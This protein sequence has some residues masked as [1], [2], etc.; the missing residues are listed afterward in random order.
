MYCTKC[1]KQLFDK[2]VV[3]P[4]CHTK[5]KNMTPNLMNRLN[6]SNFF[7]VSDEIVAVITATI[8][9]YEGENFTIKSISKQETTPVMPIRQ[10]VNV[11]N[12]SCRNPYINGNDSVWFRL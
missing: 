1:G 6:E 5:T 8:M 12:V 10:T 2:A 3:C 7:G 9:A 4:Y 11:V